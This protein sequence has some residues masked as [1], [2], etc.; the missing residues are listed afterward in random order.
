LF[1]L[2]LDG[3][4]ILH[5]LIEFLIMPFIGGLFFILSLLIDILFTCQLSILFCESIQKIIFLF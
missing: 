3:W 1:S 2:F 4:L 5:F